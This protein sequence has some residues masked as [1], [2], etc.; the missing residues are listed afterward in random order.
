MSEKEIKLQEEV[1]QYEGIISDN[2]YDLEKA[3]MALEEL[4]GTYN[5]DYEPTPQKAMEYGLAVGE[6]IE[7]C[8]DEA[9]Y[10]WDYITGYK[11]IM[12]LVSV[13]RDYCFSA[14][15]SCNNAYYGG[16]SNE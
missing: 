16:V 13:A 14:L 4:L 15:K 9:K 10:S 3:H 5:W 2:L 1:R 8:S 11:K 7:K 6:E 12:W